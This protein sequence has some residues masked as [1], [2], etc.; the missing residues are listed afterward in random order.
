MN[1]LHAIFTVGSCIA[2]AIYA[3]TG[4]FTW[5]AVQGAISAVKDSLG[6]ALPAPL[7]GLLG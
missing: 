3:L 7:Q 5:T 2:T 6:G 1:V 4:D